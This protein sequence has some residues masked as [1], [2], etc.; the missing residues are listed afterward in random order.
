MKKGGSGNTR[1][2]IGDEGV[3]RNGPSERSTS[4]KMK[5]R[6]AFVSEEFEF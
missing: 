2:R 6:T 3:S 1:T 5:E 4:R